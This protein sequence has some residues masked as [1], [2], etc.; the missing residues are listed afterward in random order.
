MCE[1]QNSEVAGMRTGNKEE[2]RTTGRFL[3]GELGL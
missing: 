2:T 1:M 3:D